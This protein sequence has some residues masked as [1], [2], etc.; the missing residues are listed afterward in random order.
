MLSV[1]YRSCVHGATVS[2]RN[3]SVEDGKVSGRFK[4]DHLACIATR[5]I[6]TRIGTP[7]K[8]YLKMS[9]K[10]RDIEMYHINKYREIEVGKIDENL[11]L[12]WKNISFS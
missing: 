10:R 12:K 2:K 11:H 1:S 7:T 4:Y 8:K 6:V 5:C 9:K 3:S